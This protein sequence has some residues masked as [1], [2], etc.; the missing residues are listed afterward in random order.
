MHALYDRRM[1]ENS[2]FIGG[3]LLSTAAF[4]TITSAYFGE[5]PNSV[6]FSAG[7]LAILTSAWEIRGLVY[8]WTSWKKECEEDPESA[9]DSF[10]GV[11]VAISA[12]VIAPAIYFGLALFFT[13]FRERL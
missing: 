6:A 2:S 5:I 9:E 12:L 11:Q 1:E 7:V 10:E 3:N 4:V 13:W 8:R